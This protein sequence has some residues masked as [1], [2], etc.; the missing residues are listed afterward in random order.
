[1]LTLAG[2]VLNHAAEGFAKELWPVKQCAN[3]VRWG[4]PRYQFHHGEDEFV[5]QLMTVLEIVESHSS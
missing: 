1:V 4:L 3:D 2:A 5:T